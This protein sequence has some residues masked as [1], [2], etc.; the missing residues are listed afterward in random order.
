MTIAVA[1]DKLQ[2]EST[3]YGSTPYLLS[4]GD[5]GRP[6]AVL[7]TIEWRDGALVA[8]T[9]KRGTANVAARPLVSVLFPPFEPGGYSLI[10]DG[11]GAVLEHGDNP[12]VSIKPTRGVLHRPAATPSAPKDGCG[13]DCVPILDAASV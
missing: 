10:I 1:L 9:G 11:D 12:R 13:A 3:R 4:G 2:Q 8:K 5:D 6:H 7:V